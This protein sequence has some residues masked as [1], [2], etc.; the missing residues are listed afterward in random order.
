MASNGT[1]HVI[2]GGIA[3]FRRFLGSILASRLWLVA[4][5]ALI[6]QLSIQQTRARVCVCVCACRCMC[7]C[8]CTYA[9]LLHFVGCVF[10][11]CLHSSFQLAVVY[12]KRK[13]YLATNLVGVFLSFFFCFWHCLA[14]IVY[15]RNGVPFVLATVAVAAA[16]A[17]EIS[18]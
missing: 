7:V 1:F 15:F 16:A 9:G 13:L 6:M 18:S 3:K 14:R 8:V 4:R 5:D 11:G 17:A 12:P 2:T 10:P